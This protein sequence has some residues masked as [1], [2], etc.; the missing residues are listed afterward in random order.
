M[1]SGD[2]ALTASIFVSVSLGKTMKPGLLKLCLLS[3]LCLG[4]AAA[5][6]PSAKKRA[7]ITVGDAAFQQIKTVAPDVVSIDSRQVRIDGVSEKVHAVAM[8][9]GRLITVAGAIHQRMGQCGGFMYHASEA[10][11]RAALAR[12][13]VI[14][15]A[16]SYAI[17]HR[18]LLE[19]ML[20][21]M[22]EK[23][24]ESTILSLSAFTNRYYTS[25]S[26]VEAS[27]WLLST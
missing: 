13:H 20:A 4:V 10:D 25:P 18:E 5:A 8:D 11:A 23:N 12:R 19:P 16:A 1:A 9:E 26:G 2:A 14:P 7:W 24:I 15:P 27:N 6:S 17:G 22:T 3:T 21:N